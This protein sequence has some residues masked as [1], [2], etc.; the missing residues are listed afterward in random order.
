MNTDYYIIFYSVGWTNPEYTTIYT[1]FME[2]FMTKQRGRQ[3]KISPPVIS[4][5]ISVDFLIH[6]SHH[7]NR[8]LEK[9]IHNCIIR[10]NIKMIMSQV[11][12]SHNS[13]AVVPSGKFLHD[14]I[15]IFFWEQHIFLQDSNN[16]LMNPLQNWFLKFPL[17]W[18]V[19]LFHWIS[20]FTIP[21]RGTESVQR[22]ISPNSR[23]HRISQIQET[24]LMV[25]YDNNVSII[26]CTII[27]W[28]ISARLQ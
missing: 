13:S 12:T 23:Q 2:H 8:N 7:R 28:W 20:S 14:C 3:P 16:E 4:L 24:P 19:C 26:A 9:N 25:N 5:S 17:H 21:A 15:I 18:S 10:I 11:C 1:I 22:P 6:H 27:H